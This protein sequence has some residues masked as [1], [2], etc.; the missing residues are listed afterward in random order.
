DLPVSRSSEADSERY[1][2]FAAVVGMLDAVSADRPLVLIVEDLHWADAPTLHLLRYVV[3]SSRSSRLLL[4][5][6]YRDAELSTAHPLTATLAALR[7]EPN[8]SF[9]ALKGF[10]HAAVVAFMESAA[11][12]ELDD[13]GV[14]LAD[15]VYRETDGNPFFV[16]EV[17]RHLSETGAI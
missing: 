3:T 4:L 10:D 5:G 6:T 11:G 14:A 1:L 9:V 15:A 7:R 12:H 13:D 17:L 2:L 8:V 16:S